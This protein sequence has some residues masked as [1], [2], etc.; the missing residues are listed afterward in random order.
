M[1]AAILSVRNATERAMLDVWNVNTDE[2]YGEE[3]QGQREIEERLVPRRIAPVL[4][5]SED[6]VSH[7]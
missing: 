6:V 4:V 5:G 7:S 2:E 3:G 1:M